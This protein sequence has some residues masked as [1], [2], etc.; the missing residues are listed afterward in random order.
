MVVG[1]FSVL[2][3][4]VVA[5]VAFSAVTTFKGQ[6]TFEVDAL[7]V[8]NQGTGGVTAFNGT[9]INNTTGTDGSDQPVTFGDNV[10]IDGRVYRGSIAG[11]DDD[12]PFIINDNA[13]IAGTLEVG[14]NT[15]T[16]TKHYSGTFDTDDDGDFISR[17]DYETDC[18]EPGS[19]TYTQYD[20]VHY[21]AVTVAE[22]DMANPVNIRVF[23]KPNDDT[24][25]SPTQY[26]ES[27]DVWVSSGYTIGDGK[28]YFMYKYVLKSCTGVETEYPNTSGTYQI[29]VN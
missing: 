22:A 21:K 12:K 15:V 25:Y 16:G 2:A 4:F 10:R 6:G 13:E 17:F 18:D 24:S 3:I 19:D 7:K 26:P 5:S 23:T 29:V 9:I 27:N 14:G 20:Y 28:V 11:T 1:V 8:G